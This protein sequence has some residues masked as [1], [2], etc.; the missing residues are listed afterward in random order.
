ML[1]LKWFHCIVVEE[2]PI[3][4]HPSRTTW[5]A[6][7]MLL[8][9]TERLRISLTPD[10][11][12]FPQNNSKSFRHSHFDLSKNNLLNSSLCS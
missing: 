3:W 4:E 12:I 9:V 7:P 11:Q 5:N 2:F 10:R 1:I 8:N 6:E